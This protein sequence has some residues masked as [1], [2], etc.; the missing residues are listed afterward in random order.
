MSLCVCV[1]DINECTERMHNCSVNDLCTNM[2]G[3]YRCGCHHGYRGNGFECFGENP[4]SFLVFPFDLSFPK[5]EC[6]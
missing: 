5:S 6:V 3:S 1:I 4:C 2:N